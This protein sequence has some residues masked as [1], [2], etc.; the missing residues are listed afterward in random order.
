MK[1]ADWFRL[2]MKEFRRGRKTVYI[3]TED[4]ARMRSSLRYYKRKHNAALRFVRGTGHLMVIK[5]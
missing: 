5:L 1:P 3:P 4:P 2:I